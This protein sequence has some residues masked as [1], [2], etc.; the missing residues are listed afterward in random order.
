[1]KDGLGKVANLIEIKATYKVRIGKNVSLSFLH[2]LSNRID[3]LSTTSH[4]DR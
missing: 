3:N 4:E 1:M 2:Y